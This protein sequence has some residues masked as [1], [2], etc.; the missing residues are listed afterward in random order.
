M[1][2]L[3]VPGG[4]TGREGG[5]SMAKGDPEDLAARA[6]KRAGFRL[7]HVGTKLNVSNRYFVL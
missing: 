1:R 7:H 4:N 3:A 2:N 5:V 6:A